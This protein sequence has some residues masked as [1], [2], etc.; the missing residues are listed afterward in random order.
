MKRIDKHLRNMHHLKPKSEAYKAAIANSETAALEIISNCTP[1]PTN[2]NQ[3]LQE[4]ESV[5]DGLGTDEVLHA[6]QPTEGVLQ[7]RVDLAKTDRGFYKWLCT[8]AGGSR[9][10]KPAK[11][12][13]RQAFAILENTS[14]VFLTCTKSFRWCEH[15][16]ICQRTFRRAIEASRKKDGKNYRPPGTM[17]SY[18]LSVRLYIDYLNEVYCTHFLS[19]SFNNA[20]H[21]LR[22]I[23]R[24]LQKLKGARNVELQTKACSQ[25]VT[26]EDV[27]HFLGSRFYK[28]AILWLNDS[29]AQ[30][31]LNKSA[32]IRN[33]LMT[34]IAL[35]SAQRSGAISGMTLREL[36][37]ARNI[38]HASGTKTF[39]VS[40]FNHKT[41]HNFG[42]AE[43]PLTAELY[44]NLCLYVERVRPQEKADPDGR[45]FL[46]SNSKPLD[47]AAVSDGVNSAWLKADCRQH[48]VTVTHFRKS[49]ATVCSKKR[50]G[51]SNAVAIQMS[52]S[53]PTHVKFYTQPPSIERVA[54]VG[55]CMRHLMGFEKESSTTVTEPEWILD[56][57][58]LLTGKEFPKPNELQ[59]CVKASG[60]SGKAS[61]KAAAAASGQ[62]V[63][64]L[65]EDF[66]IDSLFSTD[67]PAS[68]NV[69][70]ETCHGRHSLS[71]EERS[72]VRA[73]FTK[74]IHD[75]KVSIASVRN[76]ATASA[77]MQTI[78]KLHGI[79][80]IYESL[81]S[82]AAN[83][84]RQTYANI[85]R[86]KSR[87]EA[88]VTL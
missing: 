44:K 33:A 65:C 72:I 84:R 31:T 79:K 18:L 70:K 52:H 78:A 43:M 80:T 39:V 77:D 68:E 81:R 17:S 51:L 58:L 57:G 4:Q 32:D 87:A 82:M 7:C 23:M 16:I 60:D 24:T 5:N 14:S 69:G 63:Q 45:V 9:K 41:A 56:E 8:L 47:A 12:H 10:A 59:G 30:L 35:Q 25:L 46:S 62:P 48:H 75:D 26:P 13:V 66:T 83:H 85:R 73:A 55:R 19:H 15:V 64:S 67:A 88:E 1:L 42:A 20:L 29:G 34:D 61:G 71:K 21:S 37:E 11:Q 27:H 76:V 2:V 36:K 28:D 22:I 40:V 53:F 6:A 54:A 50:P 38:M 86:A 74:D 3:L 49:V